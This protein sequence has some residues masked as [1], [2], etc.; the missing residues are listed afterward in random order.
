M[1]PK[2][3]TIIGTKPRLGGAISAINGTGGAHCKSGTGSCVLFK[4]CHFILAQ[5]QLFSAASSMDTILLSG[6]FAK[7]KP[8]T[9]PIYELVLGVVISTIPPVDKFGSRAQ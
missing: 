5:F 3:Q 6:I 8:E 4:H 2:I 9:E 7:E 1:C